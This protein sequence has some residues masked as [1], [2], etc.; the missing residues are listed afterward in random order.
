[1]LVHEGGYSELHVPFCGHAT[2]ATLSGSD[3]KAPDPLGPRILGQQPG[4]AFDRF[5]ESWI[6]DLERTLASD[7]GSETDRA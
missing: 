6:D 2:L 1:M 5:I 3:I 4:A 7:I